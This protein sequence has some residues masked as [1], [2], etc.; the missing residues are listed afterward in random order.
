MGK[1]GYL[2]IPL[3]R[4]P[5]PHGRAWRPPLR[6][7]CDDSGGWAWGAP[8]ASPHLPPRRLAPLDHVSVDRDA[9]REPRL[10]KTRLKCEIWEKWG[11]TYGRNGWVG[12]NKYLAVVRELELDA[13]VV[14]GGGPVEV[15]AA[16]AGDEWHVLPLPPPRRHLR[17]RQRLHGH[18]LVDA[19][20]RRV[21]AARVARGIPPGPGVGPVGGE[22]HGQARR[23]RRRAARPKQSHEH[24]VHAPGRTGAAACALFI[25]REG[26]RK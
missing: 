6:P 1:R 16:V 4:V 11:A 9:Q 14:G 26:L 19:C 8:R 23:R 13:A 5:L 12:Q 24:T 25:C 17:H 2:V 7:V 15:E 22:R 10:A 20:A 21:G 18:A 3:E